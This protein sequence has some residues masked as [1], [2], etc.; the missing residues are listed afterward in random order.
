MWLMMMMDLGKA[1]R[2]KDVANDDDD[3]V[4]CMDE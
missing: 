1:V 2:E 4:R 3:W